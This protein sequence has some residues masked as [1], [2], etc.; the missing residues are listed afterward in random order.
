MP[1][2]PPASTVAGARGSGATSLVEL[3]DRGIYGMGP[4]GRRAR[5]SAPRSESLPPEG[6]AG[7]SRGRARSGRWDQGTRASL[8]QAA[9]AG[10]RLRART[11][12]GNL[13]P[14]Q[15]EDSDPWAAYFGE[16][17]R[18]DRSD[19]PIWGPPLVRRRRAT[20]AELG[21]VR[22]GASGELTTGHIPVL[23]DESIDCLLSGA[24]GS[25]GYYAD[26]TFG[27]GGHA[28]EILRRLS[29]AGRLWAFDLD[30]NAVAVGQKLETGGD[31]LPADVELS[32]MLLDIGFSSPQVDDGERGWS[33]CQDHRNDAGKR[34][35]WPRDGP[36]DLRMN[37]KAGIPAWKWLQTTTPA[38]LASVIYENGEDDDPI[39]CHRIAEAA[40]ERQRRLGPYTSTLE[41]ATCI[42]DWCCQAS[43]EVKQGLD[44]RRQHPAKLAFQGIRNFINQEMQQ[45]ADAM[46]AQFQRLKYG[47][48][49]VVITFKPKED[50]KGMVVFVRVWRVDAFTKEQVLENWLRH[51]EDGWASPLAS[52]V[53]P[54]RL[55]ELFPLLSTVQPYCARRLQPPLRPTMEELRRNSRARSAM[56]HCFVKEPRRPPFQR[57]ASPLTATK[58]G[59][60]LCVSCRAVNLAAE[61]TCR[62]C[63]KTRPAWQ[64]PYVTS[65]GEIS[66]VLGR[67]WTPRL[68]GQALKRNPYAPTV[69][70]HR[71]V[72]AD[73]SLGGY[74]GATALEDERMKTKVK[75]L[76]E[77]G[78]Q[79][80]Q[81]T[82]KAECFWRF[83][84]EVDLKAVELPDAETVDPAPK[85]R[86]VNLPP[87]NTLGSAAFLSR[88][89]QLLRAP[90]YRRRLRRMGCAGCKVRQVEA[91]VKE[92]LP[93]SL[94]KAPR[95]RF[96]GALP[97]LEEGRRDFARIFFADQ[98]KIFFLGPNMTSMMPL[99]PTGGPSSAHIGDLNEQ[100][101]D[102]AESLFKESLLKQLEQAIGA[103]KEELLEVL[104][105]R[106]MAAM[107][108]NVGIDFATTMQLMPTFLQPL[109]LIVVRGDESIQEVRVLSVHCGTATWS[110]ERG[111]RSRKSLR[112]GPNFQ[113]EGWSVMGPFSQMCSRIKDVLMMMMMMRMMRQRSE[114]V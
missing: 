1:H 70:C 31:G 102:K 66:T 52:M 88:G 49:S 57:L 7:S 87:R 37:F 68:V 108:V 111:S 11:A 17:D 40:L 91:A 44:D 101:V 41:L 12:R 55:G 64:V 74:F 56:V 84:K 38:E 19:V 65:Y 76:E 110:G 107:T 25:D 30:P 8:E 14:Q 80:Q 81:G 46:E 29:G 6:I 50:L 39:L 9:A 20:A 86:R 42:Q 10:S 15:L 104:V 92:P 53:S 45:L 23:R 2:E 4:A 51:N 83:P 58:P 3:I 61:K 26:G 5:P 97:R 63:R 22:R 114:L 13:A 16:K 77:E 59:D 106:A 75:L 100:V 62:G 24:D 95:G 73:R 35:E 99:Q 54:D 32:G 103:P 85:Q 21:A 18:A 27:R 94:A 96:T 36:L 98:R 112:M 71:V 67:P 89:E 79:F 28:T 82:V 43:E 113:S 105:Q 72:R 109:F 69:P 78:V 33:C 90:T 48:R 34:S 93:A 60:W 47:G